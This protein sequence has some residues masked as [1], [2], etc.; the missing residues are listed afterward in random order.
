MSLDYG[1]SKYLI[2]AEWLL[3]CHV[4][5]MSYRY[6][7][8]SISIRDWSL[9][10]KL[11]QSIHTKLCLFNHHQQATQSYKSILR[12]LGLHACM[13]AD[14]LILFSCRCESFHTLFLLCMYAIIPSPP[15]PTG[16]RQP[17]KRTSPQVP[18]PCHARTHLE[19]QTKM[20][21]PSQSFSVP[22]LWYHYDY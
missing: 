1:I 18:A 6:Y 15:P 9:L 22:P 11:H 20:L 17:F 4:L 21:L 10:S 19:S 7:C 13:H 14:Y 5:H 16:S 3:N 8:T 2:R 12:I